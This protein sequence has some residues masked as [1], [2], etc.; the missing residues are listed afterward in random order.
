M[1]FTPF[2]LP[3]NLFYDDASLCSHVHVL[4]V[5]FQ[6]LVGGIGNPMCPCSCVMLCNNK[7]FYWFMVLNVLPGDFHLRGTMKRLQ[8]SK[9]N[10]AIQLIQ[11][12]WS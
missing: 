6:S 9:G 10:P 8:Y 4:V 7:I 3:F 2:C 1:F 11:F 5:S 12:Y